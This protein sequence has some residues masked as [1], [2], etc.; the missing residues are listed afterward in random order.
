MTG[1]EKIEPRPEKH[2]PMLYINP[3]KFKIVLEKVVT[4][5]WLALIIV[6]ASAGVA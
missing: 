3:R 6:C 4:L 5:G 1:A 2:T